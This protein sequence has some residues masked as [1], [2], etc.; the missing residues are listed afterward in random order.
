[1]RA[2]WV[3]LGVLLALLAA[4]GFADAYLVVGLLRLPPF[5]AC[6]V[7]GAVVMLYVA[8]NWALLR[9]LQ[10]ADTLETKVRMQAELISRLMTADQLVVCAHTHH[11]RR[12]HSM[13]DMPRTAS[14]PERLSAHD[15]SI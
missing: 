2:T 9:D 15:P 12:R 5:V 13:L 3:G 14:A 4:A 8:E 11:A 10:S 7:H 6:F 1:M